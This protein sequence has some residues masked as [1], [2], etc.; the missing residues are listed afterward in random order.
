MSQEEM[1]VSNET[2][3]SGTPRWV[4][5]AVAVLS[6]L[7]VASLGIA[8]NSAN[9]AASAEQA[10]A[11]Q[12]QAVQRDGQVIAQRVS[13]SEET[14]ARLQSDLGVVAD[15]LKATQ[16]ELAR[17][18]RD[19]KKLD[20]YGKHLGEV[21]T[22]VRSELATKASAEEVNAK[23]GALSGDV[24]GVRG[25]LESTRKDLGMARSEFGTLIARNHE[26][27]EQLRRM[28]QRD[29]HEFTITKKGSKERVGEVTLEL[30]G[31]NVKKNQFTVALYA[32][33]R[34]FEKKNRSVNEPIFF[35]TRGTRQPME[36]VVND[37][38]KDKITG[39]VSIPKSLAS[40]QT[41]GN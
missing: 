30:R 40:A 36:L 18:R 38:S 39:Y 8:W 23:M 29:Y 26:E 16:G 20:E 12:Q 34:R 33:D 21:E 10:L 17:T 41:G 4:G 15:K 1:K 19:S 14:G 27:V 7:S 9:R 13:Q 25:D 24:S 11:A 3:A 35:Y 6:L 22:S 37:V 28:G 32:D 5:M 31:V 2:S